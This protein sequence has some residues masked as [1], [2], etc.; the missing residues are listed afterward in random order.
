MTGSQQWR[1]F[2]YVLRGEAQFG[3]GLEDQLLGQTQIIFRAD[4]RGDAAL[5]RVKATHITATNRNSVRRP[6][7]LT[8][9]GSVRLGL[10]SPS[11]CDYRI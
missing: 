1:Q 11:R 5:D 4:P 10:C 7:P 8:G 2:G 3:C 6:A 9:T